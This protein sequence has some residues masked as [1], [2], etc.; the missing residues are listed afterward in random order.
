[1]DN[2]T[3]SGD[4]QAVGHLIATGSITT[5]SHISASGNISGGLGLYSSYLEL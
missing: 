4:I 3:A 1:M 5:N 2:I